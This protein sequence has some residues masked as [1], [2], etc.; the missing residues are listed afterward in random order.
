MVLKCRSV[1]SISSASA[2]LHV[3]IRWSSEEPTVSAAG[4]SS[5][6]SP[7]RMSLTAARL[8]DVSSRLARRRMART[9]SSTSPRT[10][11]CFKCCLPIDPTGD[12]IMSHVMLRSATQRA[13]LSR[14][15][16]ARN[17]ERR[18][19]SIIE[20]GRHRN[21]AS[22]PFSSEPE[23]PSR[24]HCGEE[25]VGDRRRVRPGSSGRGPHSPG[26]SF[27]LR[28]ISLACQRA[29]PQSRTGRCRTGRAADALIPGWGWDTMRP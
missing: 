13:C 3:P 26:G 16:Q 11:S 17:D 6:P 1:R 5:S 14:E 20:V 10:V 2:S 4:L 29:R 15:N 7:R 18:I 23:R 28:W 27:G 9:S 25:P 24:R 19:L 12:P 21:L 8:S 22:R